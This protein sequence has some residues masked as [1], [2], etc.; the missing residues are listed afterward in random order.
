MKTTQ[1]RT[2]NLRENMLYLTLTTLA[3]TVTTMIIALYNPIGRMASWF[4]ADARA[5]MLQQRAAT[6]PARVLLHYGL[7][8]VLITGFAGL[9]YYAVQWARLRSRLIHRR[10]GLAP[11]VLTPNGL[12]DPDRDNPGAHPVVTMG[13]LRVQQTAAAR[14]MLTSEA[15]QA[16]QGSQPALDDGLAP[17]KIEL[18]ELIT[19]GEV[20]TWPPTIEKLALGVSADGPV[21]ASLHDLMHILAVG[22]SGWGKSK[23][24]ALLIAQLAQAP[25]AF[26]VAAIDVSGSAFNA[27]RAWERLIYPVAREPEEA[28]AIL[29]TLRDEIDHRKERFETQPLAEKLPD[30]NRLAADPLTPIVCFIDE[31]TDLLDNDGVAKPLK[32]L[33][34]VG[35][36]YGVYVFA[37][38]QSATSDVIAT[39]T[40]NN[41]S[42]RFV[43]HVESKNYVRVVLGR[44]EAPPQQKG[45]ALVRLMGQQITEIQVPYVA[46]RE[47]FQRIRGGGPRGPM[48][49]VDI[50]QA[51]IIED[52]P[53]LPDAER[54]RL[55]DSQGLSMNQ[56]QQRLFGA[57]GGNY[58]YQVRD[59]LRSNN[60]N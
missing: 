48:P 32:R 25:E 41:F 16:P 33:L 60:Q 43:F 15:Q 46:R 28:I 23:L 42:S 55:L 17:A 57:T 51:Q 58:Y 36:Q 44:S 53:S 5:L 47:L 19:L 54:A 50:A 24:L 11:L 52:D 6:L 56:I 3:I 30:Y 8:A 34:Q 18:P 13:A 59:F 21:T 26:D 27:I 38:G 40:R 31:G 1:R 12:Y 37:T 2:S 20:L 45:R 29:T 4:D 14:Y 35:R 7:I 39:S 49:E 22:S 9:S 10:D